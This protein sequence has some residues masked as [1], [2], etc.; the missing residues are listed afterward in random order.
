MIA[1][2]DLG[3]TR[4][5]YQ[6]EINHRFQSVEYFNNREL[7]PAWLNRRFS[8]AQEIVIAN[9]NNEKFTR[10]IVEWADSQAISVQ[11]LS[12]QAEQFGVSCAYEQF[13]SLG[14]DRWLAV[15]AADKLKPNKATLVVDAGTATTFDLISATK[16]HLGGW[17]LPG[18]ALVQSTLLTNTEN[19]VAKP[20]HLATIELGLNSSDAVNNA[21]WL[22]TLAT[23]EKIVNQYQAELGDIKVLFTG[24]NGEQLANLSPELGNYIDNLIFIGMQR[25][26]RL[27]SANK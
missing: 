10:V 3:N 15:L 19:I 23:V 13:S 5:K 27:T 2:F 20:R 25:F 7:T 24:G 9:V 16:Q 18:V 26:S 14:I 1:Y 11:A 17:I 8:Q 22:A 6:I 4:S 21:A 12:V